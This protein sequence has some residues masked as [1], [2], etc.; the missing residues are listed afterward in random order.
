[1]GSVPGRV[2]FF[3]VQKVPIAVAFQTHKVAA[4]LHFSPSSEM[5][6]IRTRLVSWDWT[7]CVGRESVQ[8]IASRAVGRMEWCP[9]HS[10][11]GRQGGRSRSH[12]EIA[13]C[14]KESRRAAAIALP[15]MAVF[16]GTKRF[17]RGAEYFVLPFRGSS[18]CPL[19]IFARNNLCAFFE[20]P[21]RWHLISSRGECEPTS[22]KFQL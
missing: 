20:I 11:L 19:S 13:S 17:G 3:L 5:I 16:V 7:A 21:W 8:Q 1:M 2:R 4:L 10:G 6:Q 14:T 15:C 22:S 12:N 9:A 18:S